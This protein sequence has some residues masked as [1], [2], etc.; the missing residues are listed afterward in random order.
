MDQP[1]SQTGPLSD[2]YPAFP[3]EQLSALARQ[4]RA[5]DLRNDQRLEQ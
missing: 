5:I 4:L 1:R 2:D 3:Y